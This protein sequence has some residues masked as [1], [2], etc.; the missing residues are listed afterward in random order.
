MNWI[1]QIG[2]LLILLAI[3]Q[4]GFG[5]E[6][7]GQE[8][9]R[10]QQA[11]KVAAA[12]QPATAQIDLD[13]NNV[14]TRMLSGGDMWWDLNNAKYEV[15]K[16]EPGT[17]QVSRHSIFAGALWIGG[18]DAG[19]QLK[20]AAQTYRQ[21]GNDF[22]P[23]PLDEDG[24]VDDV[25][26]NSF[27]RHWKVERTE[28][29]DFIGYREANGTPIPISAIPRSILEWPGQGNPHA[30]G[31]ESIPLNLDPTKPLAP[32]EDFDG[33]GIYNPE[34]GD[35][36]LVN[37]DQAIWWVYN[38]R[39]DI[40]TETGAEAIGL[41]VQATAFAFATND[42]VNN[43]TFYSFDV[44][45]YS[46]SVLDSVY[47]GQWVDPDLGQY[48]DD[49]VGCDTSRDLGICYNGDAL[50]GTAQGYGANPPIVGVD[51]FQGPTKYKYKNGVIVDSTILGMSLFL[52]YNNDFSNIGNPEVASHFYGYLTGTWKDGVPFT[53]GGNGRG[54]TDPFPF[55]F[56]DDPSDPN[57]W[58]E[59]ALNNTPADR[60][61]VQSSGPFRLEPGA[62]N[63]VV[64]GVVWV[65]PEDQ[66][67]CAAN[68]DVIRVASDKAQALFDNNFDI[69]DGPDAPD[70]E[71]REL[72]RE[73]ILSLF[74]ESKQS[75]N[76]HETYSEADPVIKSIIESVQDTNITD[77][78]YDF[79]GYIIYQLRNG[80]VSPGDYRNLNDAR[81][82]FQVDKR[83]N[84]TRIVNFSFDQ[85][86][87]ALVPQ[88]MVNGN[89]ND[90][91]H[92]F[93]VTEDAFASAERRLVN[94]K[95]YYFSVVAYAHNDY[96]PYEAGNDLS[97]LQPYLEGRRNIKVYTAIPHPSSPQNQGTIVKAEYGDQS[98]IRTISGFGNGGRVLE[99]DE[100]SI[101]EVLA[102]GEAEDP[103]YKMNNG[104][105]NVKVYDPIRLV[106]A[107]FELE[108]LDTAGLAFNKV[109]RPSSSRWI[110]RNLTTGEE[111]LSD[112]VLAINNE[113][114]IPKWGLSVQIPQVALPG[115]DRA[116]NNGFLEAT[117]TYA[118]PGN[119]WLTGI[120]DQDG[121][122]P[123]N[124]IRSGTFA[125]PN[126][127]TYNDVAGDSTQSYETILDGTFAPVAL[128][129]SH[130]KSIEEN[131][132]APLRLIPGLT[133]RLKLENINSIDLVFTPD[134]SKWT[135]CVVLEMSDDPNL[136]E[137]NVGKMGLRA[138]ASWNKDGTYDPDTMGLSWFPGY[139]I[140]IETGERLNI[141]FSEDSWLAGENGAD[142]IWNP[143]SRQF[144]NA[145]PGGATPVFG[146]KHWVY[147]LGT[148]YDRG[149]AMWQSLKDVSN[150]NQIGAAIRPHFES[151]E[152]MTTA[153]LANGFE[154]N[155]VEEGIIPTETKV[156]L[157]VG[158]PYRATLTN[159]NPVYRFST[160]ALAPEKEVQQVA[161]SA[162]DD[163]RVVPNP[164]YAY[165]TYEQSQL[166]NR[167]KIT[168]LPSNCRV[169]IY[170]TDGVLV[171]SFNR[172]V[173]ADVTD[174]S[175]QG[176]NQTN[177]D[178]TIDWDL[179][180]N[181]NIPVASGMY[182]IHVSAPGIG[183]KTVKFFGVMRPIDLDTF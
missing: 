6:N 147:V 115:F 35:Y 129:G 179:R 77:S 15:P 34:N 16:V 83:D 53:F 11:N 45:N 67:G 79:Q 94:H 30:V 153:I 117:K 3:S 148:K 36:P 75:N 74:N 12:C 1:K 63:E 37:G 166:D 40:H 43:M 24:T 104:P 33:D 28:I 7:K 23:G 164:Y 58:S 49:F 108:L 73:I 127:T 177:F 134:K 68:F 168:N 170:S 81:P 62:R 85:E 106:S 158:R 97:Q 128:V 13:I 116:P 165:S 57:G 100:S 72:D 159:E 10:P 103:L 21:T 101:N 19:G 143:T 64:V 80:Q 162:L 32:F 180:N 82:I 27:D 102:T 152:W 48:D 52:Y 31:A 2:A 142:M 138:H 54:G 130:S 160:S 8:G 76:Y 22:W 55:M 132:L 120:P 41:E 123:F 105:V 70:M 5:K 178:T 173:P 60:R 174:G 38:D 44:L 18:I 61:F 20:L 135:R 47:F 146:G 109:L 182:L 150:P 136:S 112:T 183:E 172:N 42:E 157:R 26:C 29:N 50:D 90:I 139:A 141:V 176:A 140:N 156:R 171:R 66:V 84:V 39:G 69:I 149:Q 95:T 110:L 126:N 125:N 131:P 59:C 71:V 167:V 89:N 175:V 93:R 181:Q 111:V 14:R 86:V 87:N 151:A 88:L 114:L 118:D 133:A 121:F 65:R 107:D 161:E 78:T 163:I 91:R 124:W 144:I 137:G 122:T 4:S 113:K 96:F 155:S 98:Q 56:P 99:L 17:G 25:V 119:Q 145:G 92:S 46:T 9:K 154:L 51:F 169:N